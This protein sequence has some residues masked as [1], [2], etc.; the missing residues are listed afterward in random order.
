[1]SVT[2]LDLARYNNFLL[3][4]ISVV[5]CFKNIASNAKVPP[6]RQYLVLGSLMIRHLGRKKG[7]TRQ[8]IALQVK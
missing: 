2:N 5:I 3:V 1:M 6:N 7:N 8:L 4:Q